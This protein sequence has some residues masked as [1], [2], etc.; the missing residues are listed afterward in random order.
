MKNDAPEHYKIGRIQPDLLKSIG[1][2]SKI[3]SE[4]NWKKQSNWALKKIENNSPCALV[5]KR[6]F[7][8]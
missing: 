2:P 8:D 7:Y 1:L 3:I 6:E 4:K 5:I